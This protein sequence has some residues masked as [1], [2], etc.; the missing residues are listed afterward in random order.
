MR[1]SASDPSPRHSGLA[2]ILKASMTCQRPMDSSSYVGL[3][4]ALGVVLGISFG[5]L[6]FGIAIGVAVG[7]AL[8]SVRPRR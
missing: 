1:P 7:V 5:N 3:G 4:V 8:G 2:R 6:A